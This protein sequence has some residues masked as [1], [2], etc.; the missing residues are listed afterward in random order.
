[1][2][3]HYFGKERNSQG[4]A[5]I[6][7]SDPIYPGGPGQTD[8]EIFLI[9]CPTQ[10]FPCWSGSRGPNIDFGLTGTLQRVW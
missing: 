9:R 8:G 4:A 3:V 6:P 5:A 1:M 10:R 2:E 7:M